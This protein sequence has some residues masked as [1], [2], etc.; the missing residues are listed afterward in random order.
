MIEQGIL[1]V[2]HIISTY[3]IWGVLAATLIEEI[4]APIPSGLVPLAAGFFLLPADAT[5]ALVAVEAIALVALPVAV[6][7]SIGS[8]LVYALGYYGGKPLIEKNE[9][10]LGISWR[11]IERIE[12]RVIRGK[13]DELTLFL[14]RLVPIIPGVAISGFCGVVRYPFSRFIAIT[15]FGSGLRAY[16]LGLAGWQ[17]GE[18]YFKYVEVFD[19]FEHQILLGVVGLILL[20]VAYYVFRKK[21]R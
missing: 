16:A 8:A 9:R 14:L 11:D 19:R 17:A 10:F 1:Y 3:G 2:Q 13:R 5:F 18:F 15:F 12:K 20:G 6:G 7:M 4:I 21:R